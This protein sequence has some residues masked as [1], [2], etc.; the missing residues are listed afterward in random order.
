MRPITRIGT[1]AAALLLL[2]AALPAQ[3]QVRQG[4]FSAGGGIQSGSNFVWSTAG[5]GAIGISTGNYVVKSGFWYIADLS[6]AVEVAITA[7][8]VEY[9]GEA[10]TVS[11]DIAADAPLAGFNVYRA[12]GD[13]RQ[14]ERL[15]E[16]PLDPAA[17][18]A[19]RDATA[20]PGRTYD[21]RLGALDRGGETFSIEMRIELPAMPLTLFQN[22]PNPFNP[23]TRISFFLP[24]PDHVRIE[25][26]DVS[27]R[28][29]AVPVDGRYGAGR[30]SVHWNGTNTAG[31]AVA[32]GV[33]Y[34]RM[35]AGKAT[36]TKKL[37]LMR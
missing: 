27:G 29:I 18:R 16:L 10:V 14:F 4:I 23:S 25:I 17:A 31:G 1:L 37:V 8:H 22:V 36:I 2:P 21:Y 12:E 5:Q 35:T 30:H 11:W 20:M 24:D 3:Y 26:F 6:S 33:F 13:T 28:R 9:D 19:Y 34:Y 32:S 15:N 7:F